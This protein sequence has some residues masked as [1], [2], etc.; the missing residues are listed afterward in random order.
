MNKEIFR[1]EQSSVALIIYFKTELIA[2][3]TAQKFWG[4]GGGGNKARKKSSLKN[5]FLQEND[6]LYVG[7]KRKE[8]RYSILQ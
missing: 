1:F 5:H 7:A 3:D 8:T 4:G 6:L 2:F